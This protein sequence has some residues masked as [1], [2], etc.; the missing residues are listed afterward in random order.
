MVV[1][2][3]VHASA[4]LLATLLTPS[5]HRWVRSRNPL[6][7]K[8]GGSPETDALENVVK[9]FALAEKRTHIFR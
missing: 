2:G 8:L 5:L 1:S 4:T 6:Q 9:C 3:Q 7:G